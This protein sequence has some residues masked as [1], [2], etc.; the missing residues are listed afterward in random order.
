MALKDFTQEY[1]FTNRTLYVCICIYQRPSY[2]VE[3]QVNYF[4]NKVVCDLKKEIEIYNEIH[5]A[6]VYETTGLMDVKPF[7][8][9]RESEKPYYKEPCGRVGNHSM[10]HIFFMGMEMLEQ[11]KDEERRLYF[12]TDEILP[13]VNN[14]LHKS[15]NGIVMNERYAHSDVKIILCKSEYLGEDLLEEYLTMNKQGS[16]KKW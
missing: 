1:Q 2:G 13:R 12:V 15:A 14:L 4:I 8:V 5:I 9:L 7:C 6:Y 3:S 10:E 16:V 11:W